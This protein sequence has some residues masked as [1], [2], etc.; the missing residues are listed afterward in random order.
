MQ[1]AENENFECQQL[2]NAVSTLERNFDF[3]V[4][5]APG[6]DC[7]LTRLAHSMAD[8]LVPP[9]NDCPLDFESALVGGDLNR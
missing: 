8:T 4:I 3:L 5:D 9:I 6:T 7:Y 2:V 1:I